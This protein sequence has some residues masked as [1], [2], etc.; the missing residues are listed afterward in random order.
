MTVV[1]P[2]SGSYSYHLSAEQIEA[3]NE[4]IKAAQLNPKAFEPIYTSYFERIVG[5]IYHRVE[6]KEM[7]FEITAQVFYRALDN[8]PKYESRG[9]PFS[10]WLFR[11][12]SNELNQWFRKNKAQRILNIDL[13]GLNEIKNDTVE[14]GSA[15]TDPQLFAALQQLEDDELELVN[16]RFFEKRSFKEI[17]D[18]LQVGESACKMRLYRIL[19]KLK[20]IL[21]DSK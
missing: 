21:S 7:A 2:I 10:A 11:I 4:L 1:S 13:E 16:M 19:E 15:E 8:L 3:E 9:L 5:F 12:A 6:N 20:Q 17:C 18:I 14:P